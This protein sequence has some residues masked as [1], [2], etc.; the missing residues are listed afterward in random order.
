MLV[1][2]IVVAA[3]TIES[4]ADRTIGRAASDNYDTLRI[5]WSNPESWL[6]EEAW[7][8]TQAHSQ[9]KLKTF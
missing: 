1:P 2:L 4:V 9:K 5:V 8:L 7:T 6:R 3:V